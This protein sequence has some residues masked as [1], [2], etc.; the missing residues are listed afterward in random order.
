MK[1]TAIVSPFAPA[2]RATRR[3]DTKPSPTT[4]RAVA[5]SNRQPVQRDST[6]AERLAF[7]APKERTARAAPKRHA[8]RV[9][10]DRRPIPRGRRPLR[11][12]IRPEEHAKRERM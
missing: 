9:R 7:P 4:I 10:R 8:R 11:R 5:K 2:F 1:E 3:R 6:S 12:A